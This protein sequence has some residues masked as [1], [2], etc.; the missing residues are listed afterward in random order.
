MEPPKFRPL[1]AYGKYPAPAGSTW[2]CG[3]IGKRTGFGVRG[4]YTF[5]GSNPAMPTSLSD[6]V[7]NR[8]REASTSGVFPRSA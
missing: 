7:P 2:A 5:A 8:L 1:E 3:E 6:I 4:A